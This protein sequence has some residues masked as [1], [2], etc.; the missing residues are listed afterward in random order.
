MSFQ[1][2]QSLASLPIIFIAVLRKG[3]EYPSLAS[4]SSVAED[5]LEL[6]NLLPRFP[7]CWDHRHALSIVLNI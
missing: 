2:K 4:H 3:L 5:D 1:L 6:P 7:K